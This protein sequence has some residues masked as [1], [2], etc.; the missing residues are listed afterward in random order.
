MKAMSIQ[1][2]RSDVPPRETNGKV[3]PVNGRISREPKTFSDSCT[4]S[5]LTVAQAAME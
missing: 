5:M 2:E 1:Q 3:T 4:S